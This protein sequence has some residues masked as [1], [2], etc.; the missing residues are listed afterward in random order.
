MGQFYRGGNHN[1]PIS[2]EGQR[3]KLLKNAEKAKAE[4]KQKITFKDGKWEFVEVTQE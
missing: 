2:S 4:V 3:L 1:A